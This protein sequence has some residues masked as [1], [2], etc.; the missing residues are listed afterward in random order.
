MDPQY[1]PVPDAQASGT[2][3][4]VSAWAAASGNDSTVPA[5]F[6]TDVLVAV[7]VFVVVLAGPWSMAPP[8]EQDVCTSHTPSAATSVPGQTLLSPTK[9]APAISMETSAHEKT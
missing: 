4:G 2:Q 7:E 1:C 5:S 3:L 9:F 8:E 6:F